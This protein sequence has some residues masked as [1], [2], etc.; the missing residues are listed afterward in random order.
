MIANTH[1]RKHEPQCVSVMATR[2]DLA[3][4]GIKS[5]AR[6]CGKSLSQREAARMLY[7][8]WEPAGRT[9]LNRSLVAP[10]PHWND[11]T[12]RLGERKPMIRGFARSSNPN[13]DC[14]LTTQVIFFLKSTIIVR[15]QRYNPPISCIH[16]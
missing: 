2:P 8:L 15:E 11:W 10:N 13:Y 6:H 3:W 4:T 12:N 1:S 9:F 5:F 7:L 16:S 14:L